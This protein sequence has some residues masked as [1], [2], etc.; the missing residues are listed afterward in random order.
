MPAVDLN[1]VQLNYVEKG[2]GAVVIFVHGGMSDLR[3]WGYQM[4]PFSQRYHT[5]AYSRR[6]HYPNSWVEYAP[7]Y[8]VKVETD[9]LSAFISALKL[10]TPIHLIGHSYGGTIAAFF[11]L[12]YHHLVR[13][14]VLCEPG[15]FGLLAKDPMYEAGR[16]EIRKK[17]QEP[18]DEMLRIGDLE[19]VVTIFFNTIMGTNLAFDQIPQDYRTRLLQNARTIQSE[20]KE[21]PFTSEDAKRISTPTL[22]VGGEKSLPYFGRIIDELARSLPNSGRVT[23]NGASH[24]V[25]NQNPQVVQAFNESVFRFLAK[26]T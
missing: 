8:S 7:D 24:G 18:I 6:S 11:T 25:H 3:S 2:Q 15:L 26:Y 4:E 5:I 17:L 21:N 20:R 13:S 9:D 1:G 12:S 22:L 19:S 23:I 14:L 10:P 16:I